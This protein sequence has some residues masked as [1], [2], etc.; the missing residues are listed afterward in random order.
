VPPTQCWPEAHGAP[1]PHAHPPPEQESA[2]IG[3]HA[4]HAT[5]PVPQVPADG[6]LHVLPV[7]QPVVQVVPQ[8]PHTPPEQ[9]C[10]VPHGVHAAPPMPHAPVDGVVQ[11]L[12]VQQPEAQEVASQTH[13][14]P[15]QCWPAAH[16][17]PLPQAQLPFWHESARTG[18]H[19]RHA[20]PVAPPVPHCETDGDWH[21]PPAQQPFGHE[22]A[23]QTQP[24]VVQRCPDAQA[25]P[26]PHLHVPP[27]QESDC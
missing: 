16:A 19:A 2:L 10:P 22:V 27:V 6:A 13:A 4:T 17:P 9:V 11:T 5:P 1:L 20:A 7:Q 14:P 23:S 12:P 3:S 15:T 18:S 26:D 25:A 21:A 8:P 24:P